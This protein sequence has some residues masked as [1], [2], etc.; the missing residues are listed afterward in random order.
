MP[1]EPHAVESASSLGKGI[2]TSARWRRWFLLY[3]QASLKGS[4]YK[5]LFYIFLMFSVTVVIPL[6]SVASEPTFAL[7]PAERI[8]F[9][10]LGAGFYLLIA[11]GFRAA[12]VR[13]YRKRLQKASSQAAASVPPGQ[14]VDKRAA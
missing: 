10:L 6:S 13:D 9:A 8:L 14:G 12:A 1:T 11:L 5:V 7:G 4:T 2:E 3:E